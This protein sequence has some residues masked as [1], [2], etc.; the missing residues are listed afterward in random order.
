MSNHTECDWPIHRF[1]MMLLRRW[2]WEAQGGH[3]G[4]CGHKMKRSFET[5]KLTF[6][7]VWPKAWSAS[8]V[9]GKSL[10]N[11]LLAHKHCN[12]MKADALPTP[13]Q[14]DRLREVN[15]KLGFYESETC[16]WDAPVQEAAE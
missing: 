11:I 16:Q 1:A 2:F 4:I 15:R 9:M 10:G 13:E 14:V 5:P 7:H 12:D 3:C 6:D 8:D